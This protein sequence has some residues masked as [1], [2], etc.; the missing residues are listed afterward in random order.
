MT[1]DEVLAE[2]R[3]LIVHESRMERVLASAMGDHGYVMRSP[4]LEPLI[5]AAKRIQEVHVVEAELI[6]EAD[7]SAEPAEPA[8]P[9]EP[10]AAD[11]LGI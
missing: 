5:D 7:A 4:D 10:P 6:V 2:F 9:P 8:E 3:D 1:H 11:P